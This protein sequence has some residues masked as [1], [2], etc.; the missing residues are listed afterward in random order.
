MYNIT[1]VPITLIEVLWPIMAPHL[2][3]VIELAAGDISEE[4]IKNRALSNNGLII[5]VSKGEAIV[6][7]TT[8]EVVTYDS[9]LR[10]LLIPVLGGAGLEDWGPQWFLFMQALAKDLGCSELRGLA[11]RDGWL[12]KLKAYDWKESHTVITFQL[13]KEL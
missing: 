3:K 1:I 6:S 7:V 2:T 13:N 8:A 5:V 9:G 11:A 4:S 12:R 10:S